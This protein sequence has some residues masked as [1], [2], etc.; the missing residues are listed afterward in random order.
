MLD[1]LNK[2][3]L[4]L[5]KEPLCLKKMDKVFKQGDLVDGIY[6]VL[7]GLVK[8]TQLDQAGKVIFTRLAMPLDT[9][10][11]RSIFIQKTFLGTAEI[12][13]NMAKVY[14]IP[15]EEVNQLMSTNTEFAR[16][17]IVKISSELLRAEESGFK[18]KEKTTFERV[19]EFLYRV[20]Q[21]YS[22]TDSRGIIKF[23]SEIPK[24]IISSI[25]LVADETVIRSM[26]E[27]KKN[28]IITYD[29][30]LIC[31]NNLFKLKSIAK[32]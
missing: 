5:N 20:S 2:I 1:N 12:L 30:R 24:N 27:L 28:K 8:I 16:S 3:I 10:G 15:V 22:M 25:L 21:N 31:I 11:H 18:V 26:S 23:K 7:E 17:L 6:F 32:I 14:Y 29:G 4:E 13:S 19:A 9:F